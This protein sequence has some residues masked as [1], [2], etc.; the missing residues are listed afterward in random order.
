[1]N[2]LL[3]QKMFARYASYQSLFLMRGSI[4]R[5][6]KFGEF[7]SLADPGSK[8]AS[9]TSTRAR[10]WFMGFPF[11]YRV[12]FEETA[13]ALAFRFVI[14]SRALPGDESVS[15]FVLP[16]LLP[17]APHLKNRI[18]AIIRSARLARV[19]FLIPIEQRVILLW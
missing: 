19:L 4:S 16:N 11:L 18:I 17:D 1:M 10:R 9:S 15:V 12:S 7:G 14:Q 13:R 5:L 8:M 6:L 3:S 2:R